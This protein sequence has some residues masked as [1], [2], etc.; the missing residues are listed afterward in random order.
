MERKSSR[1]VRGKIGR[2]FVANYNET[3][4]EYFD[5]LNKWMQWNG[6]HALYKGE[7]NVLNYFVDYYEP[8]ENI[9]IEWDEEYHRKKK[10]TQKDIERQEKI[11]SPLDA[12]FYR[13]DV[14]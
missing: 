12:D 3:A 2:W 13:Y 5:W 4:C 10:Q 1:C 8:I 6:Q 11:K 7:K 9:V 14:F